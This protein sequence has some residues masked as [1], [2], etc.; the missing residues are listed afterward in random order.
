VN[1]Q[2]LV[3][4]LLILSVGINV[5]LLAGGL[6]K[7]VAPERTDDSST[8][9]RLSDDGPLRSVPRRLERNLNR[10]AGELQLEG[11]NRRVFLALQD[12]FFRT[13]AAGRDRL[14]AARRALRRELTSERPDRAEAEHWVQELGAAQADLE[15]AFIANYFE[16]RALVAP[17]QQ[18][19][20][21]RFMARIHRV[22]G[23]L[24]H[25]ASRSR[26]ELRGERQPPERR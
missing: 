13:S 16:T 12:E 23:Q 19:K 9:S 17:E 2:W 18:E 21:R 20:L 8:E 25:R 22:R 26:S 1:K 11:E 10:M 3:L 7:R 24:M 14:R 4:L 15:R 5:G 6:A